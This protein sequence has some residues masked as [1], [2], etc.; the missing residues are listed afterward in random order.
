MNDKFVFSAASLLT[1]VLNVF[2]LATLSL[3]VISVIKALMKYIKAKTDKMSE[4]SSKLT[5][6]ESIREHRIEMKMTQEYLAEKLGVSRQ[7]V[8]KWESN[9]AEPSTSNLIAIASLFN[10]SV[11]DFIIRTA[12]EDDSR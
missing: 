12:R 8:S 2:C 6:G 1:I 7:A 3:L 9:K 5:L 4:G 10:M 11:N